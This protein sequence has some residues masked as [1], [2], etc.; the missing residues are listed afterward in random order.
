MADEKKDA[1]QAETPSGDAQQ[2]TKNGRYDVVV[3]R[4]LVCSL[5]LTAMFA[6]LDMTVLQ[7]L[8]RQIPEGL[9]NLGST[10]VGALALALG[11]IMGQR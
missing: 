3:A 7:A 2:P 6:A 10:A 5:G 11:H 1:S 4:I 8:G 9:S